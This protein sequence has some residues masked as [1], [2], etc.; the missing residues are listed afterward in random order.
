VA[1]TDT[2]RANVR[3]YCGWSA[4]YFQT[5]SRLEQALNSLGSRAEEEALVVAMLASLADIDTRLTAAYKRLKAAAVG[6]ITL[7][8]QLEVMTLRSEGRRFSGRLASTLGVAI[9]HDVW[10]G[11]GPSRFA[12]VSGMFADGSDNYVRQG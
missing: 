5:D 2:Q 4:R 1:L 11:S 6:K 12:S 9:R 8:G 3:L 10:S 7:P